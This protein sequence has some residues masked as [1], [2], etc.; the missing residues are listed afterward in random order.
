MHEHLLHPAR[1]MHGDL[2][3]SE[4]DKDA[5]LAHASVTY[6]WCVTSSTAALAALNLT[7][8]PQ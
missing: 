5:P 4:C 2:R 1:L 6:S 7:L 3:T 8:T